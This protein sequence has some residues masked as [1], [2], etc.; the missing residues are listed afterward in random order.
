MRLLSVLALDRFGDFVF[1]GDAVG[2]EHGP[3]DGGGAGR[4]EQ[5]HRDQ[6]G[7]GVETRD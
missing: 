5:Q 6:C 1:V 4:V 7:E 3:A 2:G